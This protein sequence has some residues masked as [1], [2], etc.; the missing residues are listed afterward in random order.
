MVA[1][2]AHVPSVHY[3]KTCLT[4]LEPWK[5][6]MIKATITIGRQVSERGSVSRKKAIVQ[7]PP[8]TLASGG[9]QHTH[10]GGGIVCDPEQ[11]C[12]N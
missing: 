8:K 3:L 4:I 2:L 12:D 6:R 9:G 1:V 11:S 7:A 10:T 5:H